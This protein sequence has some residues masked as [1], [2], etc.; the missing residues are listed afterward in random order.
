MKPVRLRFAGLQ[1]YREEQEIN[2]QEAGEMGIFGVFGAT[3][4]GKSTILDAITLALFGKVE[5]AKG[6]TRGI[7][8]QHEDKVMVSFE[9]SLGSETYLAERLY[10][11]DKN[12]SDSVKNKNARLINL[13][14][15]EAVM[16][17]KSSEVD[18]RVIDLL[19]M[20][21]DDFSRAVVLPQGKFDQFLKLT[22]GERAK[23]LEHIFFLE[24]YGENLYRKAAGHE[25]AI[26]IEI[27]TLTRLIEQLGDASEETIAK[28]EQEYTLKKERAIEQEKLLKQA[29]EALKKMEA[30]KALYDEAKVQEAKLAVLKAKATEM[31]QVRRQLE[32]GLK[33]EPF[34]GFLLQ[35]KELK[36]KETEERETLQKIEKEIETIKPRLEKAEN[37]LK[38]AKEGEKEVNLLKTEA[39]PKAKVAMEYEKQ[40][41]AVTEEI[42]RLTAELKK[43]QQELEFV[44][45]RGKQ[46]SAALEVLNKKKESL[47]KGLKE[48]A[49]LLAVRR[50]LE[51]AMTALADLD[52]TGRQEAD[53]R[54]LLE[55]RQTSQKEQERI[56]SSLFSEQIGNHAAAVDGPLSLAEMTTAVHTCVADVEATRKRAADEMEKAIERNMANALAGTLQ[57][58]EPCPVCG[59]HE[60]PAPAQGGQSS[61][62]VEQARAKLAEAEKRA[63]KLRNWEKELTLKLRVLE[64]LQEEIK[65]L[66]RPNWEAKK[67]LQEEAMQ[68]F[69]QA[70]AGFTA[71]AAEHMGEAAGI[72]G[73]G[74]LTQMRNLLLNMKKRMEEADK[75]NSSLTEELAAIDSGI[76]KAEGE[77]NELRA[78]YREQVVRKNGMDESLNKLKRQSEALSENIKAV[79]GGKKASEYEAAINNRLLVLEKEL[80]NAEA[81]LKE[82]Q[83]RDQELTQARS[84]CIV[85]LEKTLE[86]L[87]KTFQQLEESIEKDGF[88]NTADLEQSLLEPA[89][90][91]R[92]SAQLETYDRELNTLQQSLRELQEKLQQNPFELAAYNETILVFN[93]AGET[94]QEAVR[95]EG[96][97]GNHLLN[98]KQKNLKWKELQE[99]KTK[100]TARREV[101]GRLVNLLKGRKFVQFLAEEHLADMIAEASLRLG[102]LTGYRYALELDEGCSF[103]MRDEYSGSLRRPVSTL[104]GGETF[105]TSLAM[106]LALSSKIQLKGKYPLGFFFLDEG[107]GTLD[108]DKLEVV[109]NTLE[110]LHDGHRMVGV[111]THVQELKNRLPRY[112]EVQPASLDGKGSSV[113]L[114]KN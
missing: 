100:L 25:E 101:A 4:S 62:L 110:K 1:S 107:F 91:S 69:Q 10:V 31:D 90:K 71:R 6:G 30:A 98:L 51:A 50:E 8:N 89:A 38:A 65:T 44:L 97:L 70:Y 55:I 93:N 79:T 26:G 58:G 108:P 76:K 95:E 15:G 52:N 12:D 112:L 113:A 81:E 47:D 39:L 72:T 17:D 27:D 7:I 32:R 5:R 86:H 18:A 114:R 105:L 40:A 59:A 56:L 61:E 46:K 57:P 24:R 60:H 13:T 29:Q 22:G 21:F 49:L 82:V 41:A 14:E 83:K 99:D 23:M 74:D 36:R 77:V 103:V 53:A 33:A 66:H 68:V 42:N 84:I 54:K 11:K 73:T 111:I 37:R 104:S 75:K 48:G 78:G 64:N 94:H 19:G 102:A 96:A 3:G 16:A 9:F 45:E 92:L 109:M 67:S 87:G 88:D 106:A 34:R 43:A 28:S 2:F 35:A 80:E 85:G 63:E 20:N